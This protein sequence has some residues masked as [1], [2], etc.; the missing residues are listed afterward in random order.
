M[1]EL[2]EPFSGFDGAFKPPLDKLIPIRGLLP[3]KTT[4]LWDK[5]LYGHMNN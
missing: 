5:M 3:W 2:D 1:T 4:E